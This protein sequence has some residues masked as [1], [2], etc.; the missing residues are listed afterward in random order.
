M[1][2]LALAA[3]TTQEVGTVKG[4]ISVGL[5]AL[6]LPAE[7]RQEQ[8]EEMLQRVQRVGERLAVV[9]QEAREAKE[10]ATRAA[11]AA[12]T[13]E[14]RVKAVEAQVSGIEADLFR[15]KAQQSRLNQ[16]LDSLMEEPALSRRQYLWSCFCGLFSI[17]VT[18]QR[19]RQQAKRSQP[20]KPQSLVQKVT[21]TCVQA[22]DDVVSDTIVN[23]ALTCLLLNV[24]KLLG[25]DDSFSGVVHECLEMAF[26][27]CFLLYFLRP[28][29]LVGRA[30]YWGFR[31]VHPMLIQ[32][33]TIQPS[34]P[35]QR[36]HGG[37]EIERLEP[38][39]APSL[40]PAEP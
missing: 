6:S 20:A 33:A 12:E 18:E 13:A 16:Q 3:K 25:L 22:M 7:L 19:P 37:P 29:G 24:W 34:L 5:N 21:K 28:V 8:H 23:L 17:T 32:P 36:A 38:Y 40:R 9:R 11:L 35:A 27:F 31:Q 26:H 4:M 30:S 14:G 15:A 10:Q 39:F 1:V 2:G